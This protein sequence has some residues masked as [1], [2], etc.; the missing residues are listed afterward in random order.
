MKRIILMVAALVL[1]ATVR[2]A[3]AQDVVVIV[4]A[5]NGQAS[6]SKDQLSAVFLKKSLKWNNG[7]PAAP[8]DQAKGSKA[9]ETFTRTVHG[10]SAAAL[11]AYWQQQI[12]AGKDVPPS[13]KSS[14]ADVIA[15]VKANPGAVGY[16]T[17][18]AALPAD[19]KALA[20]SGS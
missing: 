12:F 16:V 11:D 13:E 2:P 9:R 19:V 14:D 15:F 1:G 3:S 4:N 7:S 20:I 5:A 10:R 18:G 8:V 17:S 6:I